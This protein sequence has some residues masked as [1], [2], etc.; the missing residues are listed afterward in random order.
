MYTFFLLVCFVKLQNHPVLI[1][2][3]I[4]PNLCV[5]VCFRPFYVRFF[6]NRR[7]ACSP[8]ISSQFFFDAS[9]CQ[10][11]LQHLNLFFCNPPHW[12]LLTAA[13][14]GVSK[15]DHRISKCKGTFSNCGNPQAGN[16]YAW[17]IFYLF[18]YAHFL[19][20]ENR[21]LDPDPKNMTELEGIFIHI[22]WFCCST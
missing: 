22:R 6:F 14:N 10:A 4:H 20:V 21:K 17:V 11:I 12:L 13:L 8:G 16:S 19:G 2:P 7:P 18:I 9:V 3:L 1:P 5:T 15:A